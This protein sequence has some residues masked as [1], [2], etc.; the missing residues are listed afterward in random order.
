MNSTPAA[1]SS[2][3]AL[4]LLRTCTGRRRALL[5]GVVFGDAIARREWRRGV[6]RCVEAEPHQVGVFGR[7]V[8]VG[9]QHRNGAKAL[10]PEEKLPVEIPLADLEQN[11][12]ATLLR[13]LVDQPQHHLRTDGAS[14]E[15]IVDREVEDVQPALVEFVD[16]EPHDLVVVFGD[17]ADAVPLPQATEEVFFGPRVL[18]ALL[19]DAEHVR[20]IAANEPADLNV[21]RLSERRSSRH[22]GLH[23]CRAN[24]HQ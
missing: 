3:G 21:E 12:V 6:V 20:H 15:T 14:T 13:E 17:H 2:R 7:V 1:D 10:I 4:S 11:L 9:P 23:A 19:F 5:R 18:E 16:H 22:F 24:D 8:V